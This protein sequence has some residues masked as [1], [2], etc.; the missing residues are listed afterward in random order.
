MPRAPVICIGSSHTSSV[1][2]AARAA[3]ADIPI[4]NL[5]H[6]PAFADDSAERALHPSLVPWLSGKT[7]V[8][9]V[10]GNVHNQLGL[11]RHPRPFDFVLPSEP[12]LPSGD[13]ELIPSG[14]L[15]T[16]LHK[17]MTTELTLLRLL[18]RHA[19]GPMYHLESPPPVADDEYIRASIDP[20]FVERGVGELGIVSPL[21]RYKLWRLYSG[22]VRRACVALRI[23]FV[24]C[25]AEAMTNGFL[26]TELC[27]NA[28]HANERYGSLLLAQL[29][30]L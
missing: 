13:G 14:A 3:N 22:L 20:Y 21:L 1:A 28:T 25:P 16:V 7:V 8:S 10:G 17:R 24:P 12:D 6:T 15:E 30:A 23:N 18:K 19:Q 4:I 9:M 2:L 27:A 26:R 29:E 5:K 11:V